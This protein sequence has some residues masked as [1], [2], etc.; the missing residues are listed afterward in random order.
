MCKDGRHVDSAQ[1]KAS[2][3][4]MATLLHHC[5]VMLPTYTVYK[6]RLAAGLTRPLAKQRS[7]GQSQQRE[8]ADQSEQ[9]GLYQEG[10]P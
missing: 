4:V 10:E 5:D 7:T 6:T 3:V 1:M 2:S 9:A 8:P